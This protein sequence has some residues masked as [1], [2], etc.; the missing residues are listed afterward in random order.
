MN[1]INPIGGGGGW[2]D[3]DYR[4]PEP[5]PAERAEIQQRQAQVDAK[6][7]EEARLAET[8]RLVR[9]FAAAKTDHVNALAALEEQGRIVV[10]LQSEAAEATEPKG[11]VES[12]LA[13]LL[14][15]LGLSPA[16]RLASA[17]RTQSAIKQR[18]L[19]ARRLR[20]RRYSEASSSAAGHYGYHWDALDREDWEGR[21]FQ[22]DGGL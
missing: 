11:F 8:N 13:G 7:A 4:A 18:E 9:V 20:R 12:I 1:G 2:R 17:L 21:S 19:E 22:D 6:R 16:A 15:L 5:S 14:A 10:R 3:Y